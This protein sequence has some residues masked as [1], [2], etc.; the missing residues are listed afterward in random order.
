MLPLIVMKGSCV[1]R[2]A[3]E[4]HLRTA[5]GEEK[6]HCQLLLAALY[7]TV[8][9]NGQSALDLRRLNTTKSV[10]VSNRTNCSF[11][12]FHKVFG[13]ARMDKAKAPGP[14]ADNAGGAGKV[15]I[16]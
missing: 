7:F 3:K 10:I 1:S 16:L 2:T 12:Y 4:L 6:Q 14:A 13:Q 5:L 11:C 15:G 9:E 8:L